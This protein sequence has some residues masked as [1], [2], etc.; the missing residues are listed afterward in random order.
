MVT[1]LGASSSAGVL[2]VKSGAAT[3]SATGTITT[4]ALTLN[5]SAGSLFIGSSVSGSKSVALTGIN[6]ITQSG[7]ISG[8]TLSLT[9]TDASAVLDGATNAVTSLAKAALGSGALSLLDAG[10]LSIS[11]TVTATGGIAIS[12]SGALTNASST[13]NAGSATVSLTTTGSGNAIN[14][15]GRL[16]AGTLNLTTTNASATIFNG[17]TNILALGAVSLGSGALN[18]L[19][20]VGL[21]VTGR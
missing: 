13:I 1:N 15:S 20:T 14:I 10:G 7:A 8:G 2:S 17:F 5:A 9:T 19:E 16:T 6:G 18:V 12:T 21:T 11:G 3:F 4:S